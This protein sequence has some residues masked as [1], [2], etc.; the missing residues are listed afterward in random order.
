MLKRIAAPNFDPF[1]HT[2][3]EGECVRRVPVDASLQPP[4]VVLESSEANGDVTD[5]GGEVWAVVSERSAASANV[6]PAFAPTDIGALAD[7][8]ERRLLRGAGE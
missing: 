8:L 2:L 5:V 6:A 3:I 1:R 4:K 7:L